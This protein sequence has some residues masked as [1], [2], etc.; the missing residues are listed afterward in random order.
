MRKFTVQLFVDERTNTIF[1]RRLVWLTQGQLK[2]QGTYRKILSNL[3][4]IFCPEDMISSMFWP[5]GDT[6]IL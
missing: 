1:A 2:A 6:E 5:R 4:Y 3:H